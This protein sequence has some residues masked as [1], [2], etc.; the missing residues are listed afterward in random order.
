MSLIIFMFC[1]ILV[2]GSH[3]TVPISQFFPYGPEHDQ[4]VSNNHSQLFRDLHELPREYWLHTTS[5]RI[6]TPCTMFGMLQEWMIVDEHG[7]IAF[8]SGRI[9]VFSGIVN[10]KRSGQVYWR[11]SN[12]T[13]D[14]DKARHEIGSAFPDYR[15]IDLIWA[16]IATWYQMAPYRDAYDAPNT[17][18]AILTTDGTSSFALLY[19]NKIG[20]V[21]YDNS[22]GFEWTNDRY[23]INKAE[24]KLHTYILILKHSAKNYDGVFTIANR[25][26]VGIPGKWIFQIDQPDVYEPNPLCG[27]LPRPKNGFCKADAEQRHQ[28]DP[29]SVAQCGCKL[30]YKSDTME[31]LKCSRLT[32]NRTVGWTGKVPKCCPTQAPLTPCDCHSIDSYSSIDYRLMKTA[33][34]FTM[35]NDTKLALSKKRQT[36]AKRRCVDRSIPKCLIDIDDVCAALRDSADCINQTRSYYKNDEHERIFHLK[37]PKEWARQNNDCQKAVEIVNDS[38]EFLEPKECPSLSAPEHLVCRFPEKKPYLH[39]SVAHCYCLP[40]Y[41]PAPHTDYNTEQKCSRDRDGHLYWSGN[42]PVCV[43]KQ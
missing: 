26:N 1:T 11:K 43:H 30:G 20:W 14:L 3:A 19:Y 2:C 23:F 41:W 32:N 34:E 5:G 13:A 27:R 24:R 35:I 33:Y 38:E 29:D 39:G 37:I 28:F 36:I 31:S 40:D 16:V 22:A 9:N 18:Q 21:D 6:D 42:M 17:F 12:A 8:S 4:T 15:N 7:V 10:L 25:S